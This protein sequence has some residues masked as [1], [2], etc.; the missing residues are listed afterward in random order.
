MNTAK[1]LLLPIA[2]LLMFLL[3]VSAVPPFYLVEGLANT[4]GYEFSSKEQYVQSVMIARGLYTA[5]GLMIVVWIGWSVVRIGHKN[6]RN[7][8]D[9]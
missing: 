9:I 4:F 1:K 6:S 5:I 8:S 2:I 3:S 7:S